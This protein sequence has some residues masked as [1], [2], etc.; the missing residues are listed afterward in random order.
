MNKGIL[1]VISGPSGA[2]KGTICKEVLKRD[3]SLCLSVSATTRKPR[4]GEKEGVNYYFLDK[5]EFEEMIKNDQFLEWAEVYGNYYGTPKSYVEEKLKEGREV[6]LEIDIQGAM[7]ARE[8]F[9][10]GVFIFIVP[11]SMDELEKR[12][13]G[14]ATETD[15]EIKL[16]FSKAFSE[17][18]YI[19]KYDYIVVNDAVSEAAQKVL[20]II[21]AEKC[22]VERNLDLYLRLENV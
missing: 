19:T 9:P 14:R 5:A 8:K 1:I 3:P 18:K 6:I 10:D 13:K 15:E 21:T 2:G 4:S 22:K 20:A 11:P 12:I 16:R 7:K 17:L